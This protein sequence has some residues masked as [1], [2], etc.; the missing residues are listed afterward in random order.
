MYRTYP[1]YEFDEKQEDGAGEGAGDG[2]AQDIDTNL[3]VIARIFKELF[4]CYHD[5]AENVN[6]YSID[7]KYPIKRIEF[8]CK[9]VKQ[10][11]LDKVE[12]NLFSIKKEI[13]INGSSEESIN[14]FMKNLVKGDIVYFNGI[15]SNKYMYYPDSEKTREKDITENKKLRFVRIYGDDIDEKNSSIQ[16][17]GITNNYIIIHK[18][19]L[20]E[21]NKLI[22]TVIPQLSALYSSSDVEI[23]DE[24]IQKNFSDFMSKCVKN[25][26]GI[27]ENAKININNYLS[28]AL[29]VLYKKVSKIHSRLFDY[30]EKIEEEEE[31]TNKIHKKLKYIV[32]ILVQKNE[33]D[34]TKTLTSEITEIQQLIPKIER[35]R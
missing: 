5:R 20:N 22:K 7:I 6:N 16:T 25:I 10:L 26:D 9:G 17:D 12:Q 24:N 32:D 8:K 23:K 3:N 11:D 1:V 28:L 29:S 4:M 31:E 21:A 33:K 35:R 27:D 13:D 15:E 34:T 14:D 2:A 30:I 18:S 19:Y